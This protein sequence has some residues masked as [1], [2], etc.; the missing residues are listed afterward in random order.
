MGPGRCRGKRL[1][2][3]IWIG[4]RLSLT[5]TLPDPPETARR[6]R[7]YHWGRYRMPIARPA[8]RAGGRLGRFR[9][10]E[11]SFISVTTDDWFLAFALVHLGYLGNVFAYLVDRHDPSRAWEH[12]ALTPFGAGLRI[13]PS[14]VGGRSRFDWGR[15]HVDVRWTGA[16]EVQLDLPLSRRGAAERLHGAFRVEPEEALALLHPLRPTRPAY[17]HKAAAMPVRGLVRFGGEEISL[18]GGLA[19]LD[20][21]RSV[22][23][24]DTRW[25]WG[26]I[27][28]R[29]QDGRRVGLN[30]SA[31]VYDDETG[32]S[33]ENALFVDGRV[34]PLAGVD[35]DLQLEPTRDPWRVYSRRDR[36]IDLVFR[37]AGF[38]AQR[39]DLR[40]IRSDFVQA[41]GTWE[42]TV[43]V[44]GVSPIRLES[45]FGVAEDHY[46]RW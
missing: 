14:S 26:S 46:A 1:G 43:A 28:A 17:T 36:S 30:L 11:W 4:R 18:D 7:T 24:R 44:D 27:A 37:P 42:G 33:R 3:D 5:H 39:L 38:R 15:A 45:P 19:A 23:L 40:L 12:E 8:I 35:F 20:W 41:F 9:L 10:K 22:A 32:S 34:L 13:A 6:G 29:L 25:K 31:E 21:T 2:S 16:W